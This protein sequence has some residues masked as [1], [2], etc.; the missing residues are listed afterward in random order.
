MKPELYKL[1]LKRRRESGL[2][3]LEILV[4]STLLVVIVFGLL[5]MFNQTQRAFKA[6][7]RQVDVMEGGRAALDLIARDVEQLSA[8]RVTKVV[9]L[10]AELQSSQTLNLENPAGVSTRSLYLQKI[11]FLSFLTNWNG[12]G[13]QVVDPSNPNNPNIPIG[14]LYRFSTNSSSQGVTNNLF[15]TFLT[16]PTASLIGDRSLNR[17]I[18]GVVHLQVLLYD[19]NGQILTNSPDV[20]VTDDLLDPNPGPKQKRFNLRNGALPAYVE[21]EL[22]ILD[23]QTLAKVKP[24]LASS[25]SPAA[26]KFLERQTGKIY[27][28]RQQIPIRTAL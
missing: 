12:I 28:F 8:S 7:M 4:A 21:L 10:D 22:G 2:T 20:V 27:F 25:N 26:I 18:D 11:F 16:G 23:S 9:N 17:I 15:N 13:F 14:S 3:L 1:G 5:M 24:M 19:K 6:S